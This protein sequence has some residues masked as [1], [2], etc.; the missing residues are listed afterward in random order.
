MNLTE[1]KKFITNSLTDLIKENLDNIVDYYDIITCYVFDDDCHQAEIDDFVFDTDSPDFTPISLD[2]AVYYYLENE[3]CT[4]YDD[5]KRFVGSV[6]TNKDI[7]AEIIKRAENVFKTDYKEE[8]E[9]YY[10]PFI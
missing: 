9:R 2:F 1:L 4:S 8:Y 6:L 10:L 5:F 7:V 3:F